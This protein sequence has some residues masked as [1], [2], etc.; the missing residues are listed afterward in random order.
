MIMLLSFHLLSACENCFPSTMGNS[1]ENIPESVSI[2]SVYK[3][4]G[5]GPR[6]CGLAMK[7]WS[8]KDS[9]FIVYSEDTS[10]YTVH[11]VKQKG[12]SLRILAS[13]KAG[14][15]QY[16][17]S[18]F[19]FAPY[20]VKKNLTAIIIRFFTQGPT[21]GGGWECRKLELF[22]FSGDEIRP[23]LSTLMNYTADGNNIAYDTET[24]FA[25][26]ESAVI[27]IGKP[28]ESGYNTLV[29]KVDKK[30][31][32]YKYDDG[33]YTVEDEPDCLGDSVENCF[34]PG[35]EE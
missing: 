31:Y 33:M 9:L 22:E 2:D 4:T 20:K 10:N 18:E 27:G 34:C 25:Y 32:I 23:I 28:D 21:K 19:D 24:Y 35:E 15:G 17:F 14:L 3:L 29:K 26:E 11:V 7:K 5:T 8:S 30:R 1:K 12:K 13:Y 16:R 6:T